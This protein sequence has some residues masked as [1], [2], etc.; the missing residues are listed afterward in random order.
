LLIMVGTGPGY[1]DVLKLD[2]KV[3]DD[4]GQDAATRIHN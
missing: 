3:G 1:W 2:L 4:V